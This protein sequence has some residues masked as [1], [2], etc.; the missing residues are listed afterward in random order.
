MPF[1]IRIEDFIPDIDDPNVSRVSPIDEHG[2][3]TFVFFQMC[4]SCGINRSQEAIL[5]VEPQEL[6]SGHTPERGEIIRNILR[7]CY[8]CNDTEV[9]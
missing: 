4:S 1:N 8:R 5:A 9:S 6:P 7:G 2:C 3:A